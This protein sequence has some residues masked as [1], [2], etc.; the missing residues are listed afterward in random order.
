MIRK[1]CQ[2]LC[3]HGA[4]GDPKCTVSAPTGLSGAVFPQPRKSPSQPNPA[5]Q[6]HFSS[7]LTAPSTSCPSA[8]GTAV[9]EEATTGRTA[10]ARSGEP[11]AGDFPAGTPGFLFALP[12]APRQPTGFR[13]RLIRTFLVG[14]ASPGAEIASFLRQLRDISDRQQ[15]CGP[16][17]ASSPRAGGIWEGACRWQAFGAGEATH[18]GECFMAP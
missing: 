5:E 11:S 16:A 14:S 4:T 3:C 1:V 2:R 10:S 6:K 8:Y 15:A 17:G 7:Q 18:G 12:A 13:H 9:T